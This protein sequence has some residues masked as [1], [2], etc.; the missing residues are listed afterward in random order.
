LE[1]RRTLRESALDAFSTDRQSPHR[2]VPA[3]LPE[4]PF[5]DNAFDLALCSHLL[6][7]WSD[8]LDGRG[9]SA[10]CASCSA[11]PPKCGSSRWS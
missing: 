8:V 5:A 9:T 4:L 7:T 2:Y 10:V 11:W 1:R 6:F 3:Q